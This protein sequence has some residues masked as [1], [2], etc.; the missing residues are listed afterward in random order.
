MAEE[1]A[2]GSAPGG[3]AE[4]ENPRYA[5]VP[6]LIERQGRSLGVVLGSRLCDAAKKGKASGDLGSMT[7]PALRKLFKERC[8]GREG[9]LSPQHPTLETALR[10]LLASPDDSMALSEI[11]AAVTDLWLTSAWSPSISI[12]GMRRL[13][14]NAASYGIARA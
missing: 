12:G 1:K 14:D 3:A 2:S 8:A 7:Y 4:E 9:Y 13:L 10:L 6:S 5:V 11:Y